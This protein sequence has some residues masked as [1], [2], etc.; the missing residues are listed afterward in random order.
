[1]VTDLRGHIIYRDHLLSTC[2][3][4]SEKLTFLTLWYAHVGVRNINFSENSA[5]TLNKWSLKKN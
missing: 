3:K 1:M 2:V 5:Y 4:F